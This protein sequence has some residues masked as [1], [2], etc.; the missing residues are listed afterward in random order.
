MEVKRHNHIKETRS[1]KVFY[2]FNGLFLTFFFLIT[3]YPILCM[4]SGAISS[5]DAVAKGNVTFYPI[6]FSLRGFELNL[7]NDKVITGFLNSVFYTVVGTALNLGITLLTAYVMSRKELPFR[8]AISFFMAFTMWFSGGMIPNFLLIRNLG[9]FNTRWALLIPGMLNVWNMIVCRTYITS[10][11]P[12]EMY[13]A[14]SIDGCGYVRFWVK[15]VLPLSTAII[16]VLTL[17]YSI[18]H[19]NSY[20]NALLYVYDQKKQPLQLFLRSMLVTDMAADFSDV[21]T[22]TESLGIQELMKNS[23]ILI[24]CLPL[25]I[26]YPFVQRYFVEGVMIGSVKG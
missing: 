22:A 9:M 6:G 14:A 20:F 25:W 11:I 21:D 15:M 7:Q 17:W 26:L 24:A 1:E 19:W 2:F 23:M 3:L 13:E 16:A 8:S 4:I 18:S 5:P 12:D 10:T